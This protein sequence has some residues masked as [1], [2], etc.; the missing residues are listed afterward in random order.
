MQAGGASLTA[1]GALYMG[2]PEEEGEDL[3]YASLG[4][5]AVG[6]LVYLFSPTLAGRDSKR[7]QF[8]IAPNG[9][10]FTYRF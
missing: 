1:Y 9:C 6:G 7:T 3:L 10:R 5:M 4:L 8:S 2:A